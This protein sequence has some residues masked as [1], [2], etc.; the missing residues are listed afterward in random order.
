MVGKEKQAEIPINLIDGTN[1]RFF[2]VLTPVE[3]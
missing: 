1:R 2:V 3:I